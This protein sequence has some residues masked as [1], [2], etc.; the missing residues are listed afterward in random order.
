MAKAQVKGESSCDSVFSPLMQGAEWVF[1]VRV[2]AALQ[3]ESLESM[4]DEKKN[5]NFNQIMEQQLDVFPY[6]ISF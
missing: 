6:L 5:S 2:F 4:N 3:N 1:F